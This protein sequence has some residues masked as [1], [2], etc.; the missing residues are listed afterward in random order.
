MEKGGSALGKVLRKENAIPWVFYM[1]IEG[2]I[3][4]LGKPETPSRLL[5]L[6]LGGTV[7]LQDM[8]WEP[9]FLRGSS[10]TRLL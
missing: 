6:F 8:D 9:G 10:S 2:Y 3:E 5:G 1:L 4:V 7:P